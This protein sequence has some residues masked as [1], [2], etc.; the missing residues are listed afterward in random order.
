MEIRFYDEALKKELEF[1]VIIARIDGKWIF[2]RHRDRDTWEFPGGHR[3]LKEDIRDTARRELWEE[4]GATEFQLEPVS[5][6]GIF[7]EGEEPSFGA[8]F[9]AEVR[10]YGTRPEWSEIVENSLQMVSP[11]NLTYPDLQPA[12]FGQVQQWLEEG[13]F[14]SEQSGIFELLG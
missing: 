13:N 12:L 14:F 3:K 2:C 8:L 4:T 11:P 5:A 1:A 9:F 10:E 7:K 6:Y